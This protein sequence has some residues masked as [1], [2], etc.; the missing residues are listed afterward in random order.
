MN[1]IDKIDNNFPELEIKHLAMVSKDKNNKEIGNYVI[2]NVGLLQHKG[3]FVDNKFMNAFSSTIKP[4]QAIMKKSLYNYMIDTIGGE[5]K[6]RTNFISLFGVYKEIENHSYFVIKNIEFPMNIAQRAHQANSARGVGLIINTCLEVEKYSDYQKMVKIRVA[7]PYND[8]WTLARNLTLKCLGKIEE[9]DRDLKDGIFEEGKLISF[10]G[11][12]NLYAGG[13]SDDFEGNKVSLTL[14]ASEYSS[15]KLP[16]IYK[17]R[18]K[19]LFAKSRDGLELTKEQL[20]EAMTGF[21]TQAK[22]I[23]SKNNHNFI[24]AVDG[25]EAVDLIKLENK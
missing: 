3:V 24:L 14:K 9:L 4:M 11:G 19:N 18:A 13:G 10:S 6:L 20:Q 12:I 7:I 15:V 22:Q 21:N 1:N 25:G 16:G 17:E 23:A 2:V 5:A 8:E